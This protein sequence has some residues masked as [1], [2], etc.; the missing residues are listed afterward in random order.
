VTKSAPKAAAKFLAYVRS[1]AGQEI[2]ASKGFRPVLPGV[3]VGT[4]KGANDPG[5]PFPAVAKLTTIADLG[6]WSVVNDKFFGDNGIVTQI[7][8]AA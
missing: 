3:K 4:V 5:N 7:E 1:E 2:F 8:K 6:G